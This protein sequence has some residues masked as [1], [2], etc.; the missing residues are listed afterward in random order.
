MPELPKLVPARQA[1]RQAL[2]KWPLDR[3]L[4]R[5]FSRALL[6][7]K[8]QIRPSQQDRP[9][10]WTLFSKVQLLQTAK[11][12]PKPILQLRLPIGWLILRWYPTS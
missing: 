4:S 2:V 7:V 3:L 9:E 1:R 12:L 8:Y 6:K 10:L 5:A 11:L